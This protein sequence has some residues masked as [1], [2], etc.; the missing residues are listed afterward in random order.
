MKRTK[1]WTPRLPPSHTPNP[2]QTPLHEIMAAAV[3]IIGVIALY[4][5]VRKQ[6]EF[7]NDH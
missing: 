6:V 3:P 4:V 5:A 2:S 7:M 1:R